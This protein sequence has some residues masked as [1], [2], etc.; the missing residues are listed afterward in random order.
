MAF[1]LTHAVVQQCDLK[2]EMGLSTDCLGVLGGLRTF[3]RGIEFISCA[4]SLLN[5]RDFHCAN[6]VYV[7]TSLTYAT[8]SHSQRARQPTYGGHLCVWTFVIV[9]VSG[10]CGFVCVRVCLVFPV[11]LIT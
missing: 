7:Q 4:Y 6:V 11:Q 1:N 5:Y 2:M 9:G 10:G 3:C 8:A